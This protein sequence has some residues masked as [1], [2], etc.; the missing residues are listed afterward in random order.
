[1]ATE[2]LLRVGHTIGPPLRFLASRHLA[3]R[4]PFATSVNGAERF[5]GGSKANVNQ[6]LG[7]L[8]RVRRHLACFWSGA[9]MGSGRRARR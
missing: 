6:F 8:I 1:V 2:L 5:G 4:F 7:Q 3:S 9:L